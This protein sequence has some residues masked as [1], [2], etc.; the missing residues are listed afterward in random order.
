VECQ[1]TKRIWEEIVVWV[2]IEDLKSSNWKLSHTLMHWWENLVMLSG[3]SKKGLRSL[4]ILV[5][6]IIWRERNARTFD[7]RFSTSQQIIT[8]IKCEAAA[9]IAAGARQLATLLSSS[10]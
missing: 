9:W 7:L 2:A 3:C 1:F 10:T 6:W 5:N 4:L 8:L